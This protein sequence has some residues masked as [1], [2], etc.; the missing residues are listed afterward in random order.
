MARLEECHARGFLYRAIG[1]CNDVKTEL[2]KCLAAE[3]QE[4]I[5]SNRIKA[6][7]DR[8]NVRKR[9]ADIDANS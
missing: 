9:W 2:N 3:R 6:L 7:T 8:E 5:R 4:R 1:M